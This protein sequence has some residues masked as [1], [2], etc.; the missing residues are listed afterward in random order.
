[1]PVSLPWRSRV[2]EPRF[3]AG[4]LVRILDLPVKGHMRTPHYVRGRQGRIER[5][6]G[7]F[8]DPEIRAY[9]RDGLPPKALYM[10]RF[11]QKDLWPHYQ[12]DAADSVVLDIF[13]HWLEPAGEARHGA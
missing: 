1:M 2:A 3:A 5:C 13:E 6:H 12:G 8:P 7:R 11:R 9:G 4:S 10:I